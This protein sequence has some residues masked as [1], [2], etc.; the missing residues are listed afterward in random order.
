M[1]YYI[2]DTHFFHRSLNEKMDQRGFDDIDQ[3][4]E[5]MID[6]WNSKVR[7]NDEVV[8]LGDF[9][10]GNAKETTEILD[11]LKGKIYLIRGN[12]D[13]FLDDKNFDASRF[14]W[15]KDYAELSE[16][17]RKIV[18]SHYPIACY[19]GQYRRD[20]FGNPKTFM[21]HGHIH[22][23]QDQQFLDAYQDYIQQQKH[24]RIG[25]GQMENVPC[26]LINCFCMYSDYVPMT[27]DEWIE[28]DKQRRSVL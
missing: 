23:T 10:W 25:N 18:L 20:E 1:R 5:Y 14:V 2:A 24:P 12:H 16:N 15:I 7:K 13:R 22:A 3:M 17:K 28:I 26:Q 27:L 8:V 9:S 4:N 6:Q 19:N 21:L 11:E